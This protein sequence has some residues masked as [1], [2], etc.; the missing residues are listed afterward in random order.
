[1][2]P[3][4]QAFLL[5]LCALLATVGLLGCCHARDVDKTHAVEKLAIATAEYPLA[6]FWK[7]SDSPGD[8]GVAITPAGHG[9]YSLSFCGPVADARPGE[10]VPDNKIVGDRNFRVIDSNTI[11]MKG[12]AGWTRLYRF[13]SRSTTRPAVPVNAS[14][15]VRNV[16]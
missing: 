14:W 10:W 4:R 3:W 11:E 2:M 13:A 7:W 1:M 8:S 5:T 6:G 12:Q 16:G 9:Y 15:P